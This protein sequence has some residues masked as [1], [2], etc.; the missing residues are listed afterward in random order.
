MKRNLKTFAYI[1]AFCFLL[2]LV[3]FYRQYSIINWPQDRYRNIIVYITY[4]FLIWV[5]GYSIK[6]RILNRNLRFYIYI[7]VATMI[8]WV[9]VRFLQESVFY[10]NIYLMRVSGYYISL[11]IVMLPLL[12]FYGVLSMDR[13]DNFKFSRKWFLLLIPAFTFILLAITNEQHQLIFKIL[14]DEG[15]NLSFH[16][17]IGIYLMTLW[18]MF[19]EVAKLVVTIY[20]SRHNN[21]NRKLKLIPIAWV[22]LL[23]LCLAPYFLTSFVAH[24]EVFEL[25]AQLYMTEIFIWE[26]CIMI[27][28]VPSN[29]MYEEAFR[30]STVDM[31]I[32]DTNGNVITKSQDAKPCSKEDFLKL[33]KQGQI[34]TEKNTQLRIAQNKKTYLVW[35]NDLSEMNK[36]ID[37]INNTSKI[38]SDEVTIL[39]QEFKVKNEDSR[40]SAK[41]KIYNQLTKDVGTQ[42]ELLDMFVRNYQKFSN[43]NAI[44]CRVIFIGTF[45]K[46]YCNLGLISQKNGII[47]AH[48]LY[49]SINDMVK[50]LKLL[51]IDSAL[52][53]NTHINYSSQY[54]LF[55]MKVFELILEKTKFNI[56][57][58]DINI[59]DSTIMKIKSDEEISINLDEIKSE[60]DAAIK[61]SI[62]KADDSLCFKFEEVQNE[63]LKI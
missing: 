47:E 14:P 49:L 24:M 31:Q 63:I 6:K 28:A 62:Q 51:E 30:C 8:I 52:R 41:D 33:K 43:Q 23:P 21:D 26:T 35:K 61:S 9:T 60:S 53:I 3:S 48:D 20:K 12:G 1:F 10:K 19:F 58:I 46:R 37:E 11:I 2:F 45:V 4:L 32:L 22:I 36:V 25:T 38:L 16:P 39:N 57:S 17:N 29:S 44:W 59:D 13:D 7:E 50:C 5:W 18:A 55:I 27:G 42:L 15:I 54:G 56:T 34:L 40:I